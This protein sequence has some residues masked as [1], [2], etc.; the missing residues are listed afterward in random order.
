MIGYMKNEVAHAIR[1]TNKRWW[2]VVDAVVKGYN[3]NHVRRNTLMMPKDADNKENQAQVIRQL[4]SANNTDN[5]QSTDNWSPS[6]CL[7]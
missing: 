5:P 7:H 3:T 2:A 4:E 6:K 1:G